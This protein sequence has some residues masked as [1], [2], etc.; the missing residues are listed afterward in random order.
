MSDG[1]IVRVNDEELGVGWI[2]EAFSYG[3]S[4]CRKRAGKC[5]EK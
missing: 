1:E 2:A 4:L 3:F 5:S